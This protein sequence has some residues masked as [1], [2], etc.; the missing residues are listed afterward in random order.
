MIETVDNKRTSF[1]VYRY[2][3][4]A[5]DDPTL[6]PFNINKGQLMSGIVNYNFHQ[7]PDKKKEPI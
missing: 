7:K 1:F 3:V 4:T 6:F 2:F 5:I